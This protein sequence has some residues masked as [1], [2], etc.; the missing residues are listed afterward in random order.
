[1]RDDHQP[2]RASARTVYLIAGVVA[3]LLAGGFLLYRS[4]W[5]QRQ[6][7]R[8]TENADELARLRDADLEV[9]PPAD[10]TVGW[11]QW[12]GPYRDGRAPAGPLRTDWGSKPPSQLWK[13][14][15]GGG[16]ASFAVTGGKLYTQDRKG[17]SDRVLCLDANTGKLLWD[18]A[19][20]GGE[21]GKDRNYANGPRA[22]PTVEGT[23]VYA[24]S[25]A[26]KLICLESPDPPGEPPRV[27]WE[28]D[29][30]AEFQAAV[31]QWGVACSPLVEGDLV[32]VT[33]GGA[34]GAVVAF[35]RL[36]GAVRWKFGSNP[37]GYSSP[38][39]AT[40][41]G[42]RVI[43]AFVGDALLCLGTDG[44]LLGSFGWETK[45][46]GNIATPLVV[47]DYVF[48]SAA[49][50]MGCA[51]LRIKPDGDRVRLET[52]YTRRNKV[53]L[54]HHS[55]CVYRDGF[56]YGCSGDQRATFRC[57]DFR[58][59]QEVEGWVPAE[60]EGKHSKGT[61]LLADR[62]LIIL[63]EAGDLALVE[64]TPVE[65]RQVGRLTPGL[66][67]RNNWA[68]PVL[69]DGRLYLRDDS[70]ILCLDVRP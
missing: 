35:D 25:G 66:S 17:G 10:P 30:M 33:P 60:L 48:I 2:R 70:K 55:T 42:V 23:R 32:V 51:L 24:V 39:A 21:P 54:T 12:R 62:H 37:P 31:P 45:H 4:G 61:V 56:L 65:F 69:V 15:C 44:V 22:T 9:P 63:T 40:I 36:T 20:S 52:V 50:G 28:H 18:H 8:D 58:T 19:Y 67:G 43:F 64:A 38:I 49:Y 59:G 53:M 1:M 29:L 16:F 46:H 7:A 13:A 34:D 47:D 26:G 27:A 11:P 14:E 41:H 5:V 68:L 57:A 6:F 3:V